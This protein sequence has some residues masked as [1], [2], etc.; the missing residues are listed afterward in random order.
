VLDDASTDHGV[1]VV[2][3]FGDEVDSV[4]SNKNRCW[5]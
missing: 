4:R 1:D 2:S 3:D 5:R